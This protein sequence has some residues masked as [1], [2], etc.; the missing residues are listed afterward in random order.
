MNQGCISTPPKKV[1]VE[2]VFEVCP[3]LMEEVGLDFHFF[4]WGGHNFTGIA[5]CFFW[6]LHINF[7]LK[8]I[9]V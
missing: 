3:P 7:M 2:L 5:Q 8:L 4:F 6:S 1:K 9:R